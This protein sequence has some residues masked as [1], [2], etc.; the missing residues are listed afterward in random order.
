LKAWC[1]KQSRAIDTLLNVGEDTPAPEEEFVSQ[2]LGGVDHCA[3]GHD[4]HAPL[5]RLWDWERHVKA[6]LL[7]A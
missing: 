1:W 5:I 6:L 7:G 3:V 4:A 2:L